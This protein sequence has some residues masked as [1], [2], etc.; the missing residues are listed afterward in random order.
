M[1]FINALKENLLSGL[2]FWLGFGVS[3][4]GAYYYQNKVLR[5][6]NHSND[7]EKTI[8]R[9]TKIFWRII[10]IIIPALLIGFRAHDLG[11]DTTNYVNRFL[12]SGNF[13]QT[14][15]IDKILNGE[16]FFDVFRFVIFILSRGNPTVFLFSMGFITL[17]ILIVSL[18]KWNKEISI[19]LALFL[20][21]SLFGMQLLNQS[22]Q[23]I[24]I[25]LLFYGLYYLINNKY[26]VYFTIIIVA[27]L[28]HFSSVI[29]FI[30]PLF[31]FKVTKFYS[32]KNW[33]YILFILA[34]PLFLKPIFNVLLIITPESY[35]VYLEQVSF[36]GIGLGL[37]VTLF[38]IITP[39]IV[40]YR[41]LN[42]RLDHFLTRIAL[43]VFPFRLAGYYSY[44]IMRM[45]Y[46]GSIAMVLLI[47]IIMRKIKNKY[48]KFLALQIVIILY[49]LYFIINYLIID[50]ANIL[51][52]R[53]VFSF[54][55]Y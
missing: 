23:L 4:I 38:P 37:L 5:V 35:K 44:F 52:Y 19:P 51:P 26:K 22:R 18:E 21:Y 11:Y 48:L 13:Y 43:L 9:V 7:F 1:D 24:A 16:A 53:S 36:T 20:Y 15:I 42:T 46:Y 34:S 33:L 54:N 40:F 6:I 50:A 28:F 29:G 12:E 2:I 14:K 55:N 10:I 49:F 27:S 30:L 3:I 25:S 17:Y 31:N 47:P 39:I 41:C 32:L 8:G 45:H